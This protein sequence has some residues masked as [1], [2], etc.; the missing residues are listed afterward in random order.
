MKKL[1]I[2]LFN[3]KKKRTFKDIQFIEF[4]NKK[5]ISKIFNSFMSYSDKSEIRFVG[6]CLRKILNNEKVDDI[7]LATNMNPDQVKLILKKNNIKY[8]E[9]GLDHGTITAI[10]DEKKFEIT[11]LR[12]DISTD[13][14]HAKVI[15]TDCWKDDASRRDFSINSIY[16]DLDGNLFD[17][18]DGKSDLKKGIVKFIG[19]PEN[20]IKEDYLRILRYIRFFLNYSTVEHDEVVKKIIKTNI[21]GIKKISK[22]RLIDELKKLFLSEKFTKV[23]KDKFLMEILMLIF[24]EL[25][26]LKI[27]EK[28]SENNAKMLKDKDFIFRLC[29]CIVDDSDNVNYFLYKY[30]FSNKDK[31]RII[32]LKENLKYLDD[33]EFFTKNNLLKILYFNDSLLVEDLIDFKIINSNRKLNHL[34]KLKSSISNID[35]PIFPLKAQKLMD[36]YKLKEG[37]ELGVKLKKLENIWI[38]NNFKLTKDEIEKTI[39]N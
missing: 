25:V 27:F 8:Y 39:N 17:P 18:F 37:R 11:S 10:I 3:F 14:R 16:S 2:K 1:L 19:E 32:F 35:I 21:V 29:L 6:G 13:G 31:R 38:D 20:R 7:D 24:P 30:N 23:G 26:N 15:F 28:M 9:T 36:D 34:I 5:E 4:Q 22:E 33:K 12:K